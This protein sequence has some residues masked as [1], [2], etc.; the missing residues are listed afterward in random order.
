M[1]SLEI[2]ASI[3]ADLVALGWLPE[4]KSVDRDTL[5]RALVELI[6]RAIAMRVTP[7]TGSQGKVSFM[8]E[9]QQSTI[10]TLVALRWLRPDQR[11][12]LTAIVTAFRRFA[13]RSID[14]ARNGAVDRR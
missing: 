3:T 8:L 9:I 10:E 11:D 13:G 7:S 14:I 12:D 6:D 4:L 5:A 1:V 2:G